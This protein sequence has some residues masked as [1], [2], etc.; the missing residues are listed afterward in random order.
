MKPAALHGIGPMAVEVRHNYQL[1]Q[2]LIAALSNTQHAHEQLS[3]TKAL[4]NPNASGKDVQQLLSGI[5]ARH[6]G[7]VLQQ[8][9]LPIVQQRL[10]TRTYIQ[11]QLDDL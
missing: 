4:D 2:N 5:K 6:T 3:M 9:M 10:S 1:L 11:P 7:L 8:Q